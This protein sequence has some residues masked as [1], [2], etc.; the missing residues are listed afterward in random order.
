MNILRFIQAC[1]LIAV[2]VLVFALPGTPA[3]YV[4]AVTLAVTAAC[5]LISAAPRKRGRKDR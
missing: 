3:L 2:T 4:A 5:L 1:A